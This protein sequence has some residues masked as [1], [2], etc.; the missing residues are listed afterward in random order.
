MLKE[1]NIA[2]PE[3]QQPVV[4]ESTIGLRSVGN[5]LTS[6]ACLIT[7]CLTCDY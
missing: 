1:S 7:D 6:S 4:K 5:I 3:N 2:C